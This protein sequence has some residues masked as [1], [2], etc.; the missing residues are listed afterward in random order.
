MTDYYIISNPNYLNFRAVVVDHLN[1][2]WELH[3]SPFILPTDPFSYAQAIVKS[4]VLP[5]E[6]TK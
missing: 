2:G 3:G 5:S 4:E 6:D 1:E